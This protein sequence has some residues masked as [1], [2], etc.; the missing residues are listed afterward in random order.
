MLSSLAVENF[1]IIEKARLEFNA[2]VSIITGETG[3][4]KSILLGALGL[5][6][7][8]R[9]QTRYLGNAG[10]LTVTLD[11]NLDRLPAV[12]AW[13]KENALAS[14][15][16]CILRRTLT[17]DGRSRAFINGVQTPL[18][19]LQSLGGQIIEIVGQNTQQSLM[20]PGKH[21]DI[22]DAQC[23]HAD[24]LAEMRAIQRQWSELSQNLENRIR[25]NSELKE[26]AALLNYQL[27]EL[28]ELGPENGE[29][30]KIDQAHRRLAKKEML[31]E[32]ARKALALLDETETSDASSRLAEAERALRGFADADAGI[33]TAGEQL[34]AALDHVRTASREIRE[35][36]E[37]VETD[38]ENFLRLERRLESYLRLARKYGT[39]PEMLA[40][41]YRGIK[42][43]YGEIEGPGADPEAIKRQL[44]VL[45]ARYAA[46]S[47][48]VSARRKETAEAL[49][50]QVTKTLRE[51][52]MRGAEFSVRFKT[53]EGDAPRPR[54]REHAEFFMRANAGQEPGPLTRVASGG[55]LSRVSLAIQAALAANNR[56]PVLVFDEV[57]AGVGGKTAEMVGRLLKKISRGTQVFC[58]T[59]LPQ[60]ATHADHHFRVH[61]HEHDGQTRVS[62]SC[63]SA[64][65]RRREIARMVAGAE[66][67]EK[68]LAH[69]GEML[70]RT[71]QPG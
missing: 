11:V 26:R 29:F 54:G 31:R 16:E 3:A 35:C 41:F 61:K 60:V 36:L 63:L 58:V 2:G 70:E 68:S 8:Q 62:V 32:E 71:N 66:I 57:D 34:D 51:L 59:H 4:G 25:Q 67:T 21:L 13:L 45:K 6:L 19:Q 28:E 46:L 24:S 18:A 64:D 22:L 48:E 12:A 47:G 50:K 53:H 44:S 43:E 37:R 39:R 5:A 15:G 42:K 1:A 10:R 14:G 49:S 52:N 56:V 23:E 33:A 17:R 30:E 27:E 7:G 69:A 65:D 55:E 40:E 38:E 20:Q 9:A